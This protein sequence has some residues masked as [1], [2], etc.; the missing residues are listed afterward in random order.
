M[1]VKITGCLLC[2]HQ[3]IIERHLHV[4]QSG[5]DTTRVNPWLFS[6]LGKQRRQE[7]AASVCRKNE[8]NTA[9]TPCLEQYLFLVQSIV[10]YGQRAALQP[11]EHGRLP[12]PG[13]GILHTAGACRIGQSR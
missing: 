4:I 13:R 9:D 5:C 2:P 12:G 10:Q 8:R 6:L 1:A 3:Q 7:D 11:V